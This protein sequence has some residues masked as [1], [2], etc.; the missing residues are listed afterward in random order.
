MTDKSVIFSCREKSM[1]TKYFK[2]YA[3]AL[4]HIRGYKL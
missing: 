3:Y 2:E 4:A 1:A